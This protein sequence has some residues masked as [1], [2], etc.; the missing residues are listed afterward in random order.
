MLAGGVECRE[1]GVTMAHRTTS[2]PSRREDL[3]LISF[4]TWGTPFKTL[5]GFSVCLHPGTATQG[6]EILTTTTSR[7]VHTSANI[8]DSTLHLRKAHHC[9]PSGT[10]FI[11]LTWSN[12]NIA[13]GDSELE[14]VG[15]V[16][17][18]VNRKPTRPADHIKGLGVW[19]WTHN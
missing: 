11:L 6:F 4:Y 15:S 19:R 9:H 14:E 8:T 7:Q 10:S 18:V 5:L 13:S 2:T 3:N 16:S 1:P 17:V 12:D